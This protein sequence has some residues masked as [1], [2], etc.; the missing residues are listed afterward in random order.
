ME[1]VVR[2]NQKDAVLPKD[3]EADVLKDVV[4]LLVTVNVNEDLAAHYYLEPL[5]GYKNIFKFSN[6][7]KKS[8]QVAVYYIGKYGNCPA[9]IG[10]VSPDFVVHS[11]DFAT[12][13]IADQPFPNLGGIINIGVVSGIK[14]KVK[15]FD[16]LVSSKVI[17]Y[18]NQGDENREYTTKGDVITASLQLIKHF[19]Q[20]IQWPNDE[21]KKR[22]KSHGMLMPNVISGVIL[23]VPHLV[24]NLA[25]KI[26]PVTSS[27]SEAIGIEYKGTHVFG[28]SQ[29]SM[30]NSIIIKAV[31]DFGDGTNSEKYQPTAALLAADLVHK[32]LCDPQ[33][34]R[35][36][37]G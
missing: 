28:Q 19:S 4:V 29:Q 17:N 2:T 5:N 24:D 13:I 7:I 8:E 14:K 3:I 21:F 11:S 27:F 35:M 25:K 20:L 26:A 22:L 32:H 34:L 15:L 6:N 37:K 16:V 12:P 1:Q 18:E 30:E 23:S 31:S 9:A 33:A 10:N 36:F